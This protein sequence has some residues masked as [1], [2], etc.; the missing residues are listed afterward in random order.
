MSDKKT[1]KTKK[2]ITFDEQKIADLEKKS[3]DLEDKLARSLADY[4]NLQKRIENQQQQLIA[5]A[6][7]TIISKMLDVLDDFYLAQQHLQDKGLQMAINRFSQIL[8]DEGLSEIE[9]EGKQFDPV[10]MDCVDVAPGKQDTVISVK[11]KGYTLNDQVIRPAQ[12]VVGSQIK[13]K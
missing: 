2:P 6:A 10:Q 1:K 13:N 8:K 12:V 9:A 11:R 5:L 3:A 7:A 4:S